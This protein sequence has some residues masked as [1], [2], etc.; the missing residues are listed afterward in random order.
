MGRR[1]AKKRRGRVGRR[2]KLYKEKEEELNNWICRILF[3]IFIH[4]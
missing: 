2:T 4:I 3:L 1:R